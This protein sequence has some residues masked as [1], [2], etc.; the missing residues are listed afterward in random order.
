VALVTPLESIT[1][2]LEQ[3]GAAFPRA[4]AEL[5]LKGLSDDGFMPL[6]KRLLM[7]WQLPVV[8]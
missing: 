7:S 1:K 4:G 5:I 2:S 8:S 6:E 3:Q